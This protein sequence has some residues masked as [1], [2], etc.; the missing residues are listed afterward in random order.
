MPLKPGE[1]VAQ[2]AGG[3][4]V[5]RDMANIET[6]KIQLAAYVELELVHQ[7]KVGDISYGLVAGI[8]R[9]FKD[10]CDQEGENFEEWLRSI[11]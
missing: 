7:V 3:D 2:G 4:R 10:I 5:G 8:C 1:E 11:R 9:K 6:L